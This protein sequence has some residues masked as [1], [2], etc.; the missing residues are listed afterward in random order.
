MKT[1]SRQ[2]NFLK[3]FGRIEHVEDIHELHDTKQA[4]DIVI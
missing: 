3:Y 1:F 4:N 2:K